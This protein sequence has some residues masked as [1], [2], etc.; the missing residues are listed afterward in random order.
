MNKI[1]G[2]AVA[3][4][5]TL[6]ASQASALTSSTTFYTGTSPFTT[7]PA[8]NQNFP[9][10]DTFAVPSFN[11]ALGTLNS[12]TLTVAGSVTTSARVTNIS[13]NTDA[14][15]NLNASI[16]VTV[17]GP[18]INIAQ[19]FSAGGPYSGTVG[20]N[21]TVTGGSQASAFNATASGTPASFV[22]NGTTT[23]ALTFTGGAVS[24]S[25]TGVDNETF[26][27]G[28]GV[29]NATFTVTYNYDAPRVTVP[30]PASMALLGMGLAGIGL[31][32]RRRA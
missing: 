16:P 8:A 27:G 31:I 4:F 26:F 18:G 21:A 25:G 3:G 9:F 10:T 2:L 13:A 17:T 14:F 24:A 7:A 28:T 30:E 19:T 5:A 23:V 11:S 15:T 32:R 12:V 29:A 1:L 22:G 6:A 20:P